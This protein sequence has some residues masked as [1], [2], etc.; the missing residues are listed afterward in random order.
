L[1]DTIPYTV[2]TSV[3][4]SWRWAKDCPKNVEL[5]LELNKLLPVASSWFFYIT[6]NTLMMHGQTQIKFCV[7]FVCKC[8][9]YYCHLVAT[10]LQLTNISYHTNTKTLQR[11][12]Q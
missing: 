2:K 6:L 3:L 12:I 1:Q 9:L 10:Q 11:K 7:L 5:I 8:V 4:R